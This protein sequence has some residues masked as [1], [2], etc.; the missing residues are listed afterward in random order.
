MSDG[1]ICSNNRGTRPIAIHCIKD[2]HGAFNI[3]RIVNKDERPTAF[4]VL[5]VAK[6]VPTT[7]KRPV[8]R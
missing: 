6:L 4:A 8:P 1:T 3:I 2:L 5:S 7:D